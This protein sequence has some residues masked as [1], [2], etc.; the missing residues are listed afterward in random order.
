[1]KISMLFPDYGS[2]F[3]GMAKELYDESRVIQEYF[4]EASHCLDINFVKLC[5]AS[6]EAELSK[7]GNAYGSVF[8]VST[9][10]AALLNQEGVHPD[11]IAG[12]GIGE[13]S[14]VT[15]AGGL[16]LPDGLYLLQKYAQFYQEALPSL[17]V[18]ML[19]VNGISAIQLKKIINKIGLSES[20]FI[21]AYNA[22]DEQIIGGSPAAIQLC[23]RELKQRS[24]EQIKTIS[25]EGGLHSRLMEPIVNQLK[26]YLTKVDFKNI[27]TPLVASVDAKMVTKGE[28]IKNRLMKQLHEPLVWDK[29]LNWLHDSDII[30]ELGPGSTLGR[31]VQVKYPEK[32]YVAIN[33]RSDINQIHTIINQNKTPEQEY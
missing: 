8:L 16:S 31:L 15:S 20:I 18:H 12:Y 9:A 23:I 5:F 13:L 14:A 10:I 17:D 22:F 21:A 32:R 28:L 26:P 1:M 11:I 19:Q 2:Q 24:I 30:V 4:E 33:K 7:I 27:Q 29:V 25:L 6:S 3:V